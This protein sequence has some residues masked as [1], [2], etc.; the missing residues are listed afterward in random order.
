MSADFLASLEA[1]ATRHETAAPGG[2]LVW[3]EWGQGEP[4]V[5]LHGGAGSWRHWTRNIPVLAKEW[6]VLAPDMPGLGESA[7]PPDFDI[8]DYARL[9]TSG[10]DRLIGA[11]TRYHLA[12][13]SFGGVT[14]GHIAALDGR[15]GTGRLRSVTL[16][17]AGALGLRRDPVTLSSVRNKQGEA[18]TEAHRANLAAL[19]IA[20]PARIDAL[21]LRIQAWNSDH[22]RLRSPRLIRDGALREAVREITAPL[23]VIYGE[24]DAIAYPYMDER[25]QLFH[26]LRPDVRMQIIPQAGHWVAFEAAEVFNPLLAGWLREG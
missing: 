12:G 10:L 14:S 22:A 4:L 21:A 20:D 2:P 16:I 7:A 23:N 11:G 26:A 19:M 5:L 15:E 25:V 13:F 1:S 24:H 8:W 18:R 6:R 3:H 9:L 17:G